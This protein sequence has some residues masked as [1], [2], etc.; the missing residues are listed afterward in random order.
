MREFVIAECGDNLLRLPAGR[1]R[2]FAG[3]WYIVRNLE[4][5]I[6]ELGT[7]LN[8]IAACYRILDGH[9]LI[10]P[11]M[12][13]AIASECGDLGWY[14]QRIESFWAI[15]DDGYTAWR[16]ACPLAARQP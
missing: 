1:I 3:H 5:N 13:A 11:D 14:R 2:Q 8:G 15:E 6:E 12:S 9:G 16:A 10:V 7:I 4:P